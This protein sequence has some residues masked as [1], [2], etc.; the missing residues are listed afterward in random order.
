MG[1]PEFALVCLETLAKSNHDVAAVVTQPDKPSGRG[2]HVIY[3]PVKQF[4]ITHSIPV[5]Q[6]QRIK[7][8]DIFAQLAEFS[9]DLFVVAAYG[10]IL[11]KRL[12]D[13][14]KYGAINVHASLLPKHRG[15]SPI[16]QAILDG[17]NT[18]GITIMQ[19]DSGMDTGNMICMSEIA[20]SPDDTGGTLHDR[21]C[22]AARP[23][24]L[25]SLDLIVNT[26]FKAT[27]Q[28][29]DLA[30]Y[31]PLITKQMAHINW[32]N[33][34]STIINHI[35]AYNP[36]PGAYVKCNNELIKIWHAEKLDL[37]PTR[38]GEILKVC[39]K[40]GIVVSAQDSR[41]RITDLT[42]TGGKRMSA[43]D[44]VKGKGAK[45]NVGDVFV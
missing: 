25:D 35:R 4:A 36:F 30:T 11:P 6:P 7:S 29:N 23:A 33:S 18:T 26:D 28:D 13:M 22:E 27:P 2:K 42:P 44:F 17:D 31:A 43:A 1:T 40:S 14:P 10:Q 9:A 8:A 15:A 39:P 19:M 21:L 38:P 24:L 37:P 41:I 34:V 45:I 20:I 12:L 3:S 5:L 16:Q 32:N